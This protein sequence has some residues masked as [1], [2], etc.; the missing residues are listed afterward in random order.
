MC[1]VGISVGIHG[2]I[3]DKREAM[4]KL[5]ATKV[6]TIRKKGRHG[7]GDGLFL[8]V[9]AS[10]TKSW[11]QRVVVHGRRRD[12]GLGG[13]PDVSLAQARE[14]CV[15]NRKAIAAGLDP[16]A[17]K[18]KPSKPAF[19]EAA[20]TVHEMNIPRWRSGKHAQSW[21]RMLERYAF[22]VIGDIPVDRVS[23]TDVLSVLKPIWTTKPETA[24]RVRQRM[25]V[26]FRWAMSHGFI[27]HNPA[28]EVIDGALPSMPLVKE[29]FRSL[30]Y[31]EVG[32]ALKTVDESGASLSAKLCLRFLVLAVARSVEAR[33]TTWDE[34]DLDT[35]TWRIKGSR[36]KAG[37]EHR[38]PL[39]DQAMEV[40]NQA[41]ILRDESGLVFPSPLKSGRPM[42]DMTLMMVLSSTGLAERG[43][44]HG[45]RSSF[46]N[47]TMEMT[48]TPWAV[49][50]AA[51]AHALGNST[52]QAY[53]R[54]D[55]YER[56]RTLMQEWADYLTGCELG[57]G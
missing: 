14:R 55:L 1:G 57:S 54:S 12:I 49:G 3:L 53:A 20:K 15:D 34:I 21:L 30:P 5:T 37:A 32:E 7:D 33:G 17:E 38:V 2:I 43:T 25:R 29:H 13:Y 26:V 36:M 11:V 48:D 4:A 28:G 16:I 56:R 51:L 27:D 41:R 24:R 8:N 40:L 10:G 47:W 23:R 50:E 44:V 31:R 46:K 45:F 52:E 9:T 42:S 35:R 22:P 6:K 19:N 18:R 39:S